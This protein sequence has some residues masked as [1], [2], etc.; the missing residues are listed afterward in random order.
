M[1]KHAYLIIAHNN[2]SLLRRLFL[3][4]DDKR[5]DI[6]LHFDARAKFSEE[7]EKMLRD[8]LVQSQLTVVP[9]I[10]VSWGGY[11]L[12]QCEMNLIK[13]AAGKHYEYYHLLSGVDF[14]LK[15]QSEIHDFFDAHKGE[16]FIEFWDKK[17]SEY[18]FRV[19]YYYPLQERIGTYT[20]D[21]KT[22]ILR[23]RSKLKVFAQFLRGVNRLK[24]YDGEFKI[25][26]NWLSITDELAGYL[27]EQEDMIYRLF[28]DGIAVDELF[29][30]TLCYNSDFRSRVNGSKIRLIDWER[31]KPYVWSEQDYDEIIQNEDALFLRKVTEDGLIGRLEKRIREKE[32][33]KR[34]GKN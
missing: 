18:L 23:V 25:G 29:I 21:M 20:Y 12:L 1:G 34:T 2:L 24:E 14:P 28:H 27:I 3:A 30:P 4:L 9:R 13:A 11:S 16:E 32:N 19:K 6:Y 33:G 17:P 31:G 26:S 7:D 15:S 8:A 22:L 5:N 10:S